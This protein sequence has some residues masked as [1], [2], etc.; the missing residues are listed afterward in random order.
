[1]NPSKYQWIIQENSFPH[2][3]WPQKKPGGNPAA[4]EAGKI[5]TGWRLPTYFIWCIRNAGCEMQSI[6]TFAEPWQR[7]G[8]FVAFLLNHCYNS[9]LA[10]AGHYLNKTGG[11]NVYFSHSHSIHLPCIYNHDVH[12]NELCSCSYEIENF[13][14]NNSTFWI[15]CWI[16]CCNI[17]ISHISDCQF[18]GKSTANIIWFIDFHCNNCLV[19]DHPS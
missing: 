4:G 1:M 13:K 10:I 9:E 16:M 11:K 12:S 6:L 2:F 14:S 3:F 7:A 5:R 8:L 19:L 17:C 15:I 18:S